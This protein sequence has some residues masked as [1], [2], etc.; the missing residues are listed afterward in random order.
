MQPW[1]SNQQVFPRI[2]P[3]GASAIYFATGQHTRLPYTGRIPLGRYLRVCDNSKQ[4]L[5]CDNSR[6]DLPVL[7]CIEWECSVR[8][9]SI[10]C[11]R[12]FANLFIRG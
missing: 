10:P 5:L 4:V 8:A 7:D 1:P 9:L 12:G 6:S 2:L 11:R 3:N